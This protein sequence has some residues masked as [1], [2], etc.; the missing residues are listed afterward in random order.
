M[1]TSTPDPAT[2][3]VRNAALADLATML[4]DQQ[5]RKLDIVAPATAIRA[6]HGQL[7]LD[8]TDPELGP[9]GVT[10]TAGTYTP[11]EV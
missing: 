5:A 7:V 2:G 6:R 11:T 1:T 10:M 4:R 3:G 8:G 9:D